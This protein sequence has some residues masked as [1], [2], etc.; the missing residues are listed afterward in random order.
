[1]N[2]NTIC[3]NATFNNNSFEEN[4]TYLIY[5]IHREKMIFSRRSYSAE[6]NIFFFLKFASL[7]IICNNKIIT[8]RALY[9]Q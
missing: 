6:V 4:S 2:V 7:I 3:K 5:N 1:M 8:I 9:T